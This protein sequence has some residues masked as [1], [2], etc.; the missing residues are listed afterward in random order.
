VNVSAIPLALAVSVAVCAVLTCETVAVKLAVV[1]PA[2]TVTEAGTAT[3][4]SSLERLTA[5]P[6]LVATEFNSTVQ[7]SIADPV[8]PLKAQLSDANIGLG[9][10]L[11]VVAVPVPLSPTTSAPSVAALLAIVN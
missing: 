3:A 5:K 10:A 7:L 2:A 4:E 11:T 9:V 8:T 6:P 1:D